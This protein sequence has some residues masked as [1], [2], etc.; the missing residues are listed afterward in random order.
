MTRRTSIKLLIALSVFLI[1]VFIVRA[2][3]SNGPGGE[4]VAVIDI[5][6]AISKS[7]KVIELI[8]Q[9]RD[10]GSVKAMVVRIDSPGGSVAPVQEIYS[11]LKK[12][13][14]P[15]VASLGGTAASG[16]YYIACATDQIFANPGTL[17]G[18]IGV[19]MQFVKMKGLYD[20][21]GID[22]QTVKSG[23]FK[24]T[25]SPIRNLT[26]EERELLQETIDDVHDQFV[27]AI[28]DE[29]KDRLSRDE[30]L[31][32]ADGRIFSGNQALEHKLVDRLGNLHDAIAHAAELGG[33][34]GKPKITRV[35]RELTLLERLI[36]VAGKHNLGNLLDNSGVLFRYELSFVE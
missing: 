29:R 4:K 12:L 2:L 17:T 32:L 15:V 14:I 13:E 27:D 23:E 25:G 21:V 10:N 6:G 36:G 16:G 7:D 20:K 11:E 35:K 19:I 5:N 28:F 8:H 22:Q 1:L 3:V 33:I 26:P 34:V 30:V 9:Y 18:S 31:A 24:D